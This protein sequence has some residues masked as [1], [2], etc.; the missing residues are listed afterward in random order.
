[1]AAVDCLLSNWRDCPARQHAGN[2]SSIIVIVCL[3]SCSYM[4]VS[5][6]DKCVR[7]PLSAE[8]VHWTK[9]RSRYCRWEMMRCGSGAPSGVYG[10]LWRLGSRS[11]PPPRA[12]YIAHLTVLFRLQFRTWTFCNKSVGLQ[13][14]IENASSS[15]PRSLAALNH[16]QKAWLNR[17]E[18]WCL[19]STQTAKL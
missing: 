2:A 6:K 12:E 9:D 18:L 8:T 13:T 7:E 17:Y 19:H 3:S 16:R 14:P 4:H 5:S 15:S 10:Q 1:M 11:P